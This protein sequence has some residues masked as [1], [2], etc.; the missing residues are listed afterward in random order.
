MDRQNFK[1]ANGMFP[2]TTETFDFMQ[3]QILML[4]NLARMAG[5]NMIVQAP[6]LL[7]G[8]GASSEVP[9]LV[10][11]ADE[12]MPLRV[13]DGLNAPYVEIVE[14][15]EDIMVNETSFSPLRT[16]RY[17]RFTNTETQYPTD[18]FLPAL[19]TNKILMDA[20]TRQA[21]T[22]TELQQHTMPKG[23]IIDWYPSESVSL[24]EPDDYPY[25]YIPCYPI[26]EDKVKPAS[27]VNNLKAKWKS[28]Y[29]TIQWGTTDVL[30]EGLS[31]RF[32]KIVKCNDVVVPDLSKRF[33]YGYSPEGFPLGKIGGSDK[34]NLSGFHLDVEESP[35]GY[36]CAAQRNIQGVLPPYFT[37]YKLI[38]VI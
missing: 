5:Q 16:R 19:I 12:L 25:G 38:K 9:G 3:E 24:E 27:Y 2:V 37:V 17:A 22:I 26:F 28:K 10:I 4:G 33:M 18:S 11:I 1:N 29:P 32:Y 36:P 14:E 15:S 34:L 8:N 31:F 7:Y 30:V 13:G 35:D 6:Q 23:T 20:I 21:Q